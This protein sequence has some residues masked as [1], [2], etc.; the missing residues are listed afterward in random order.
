MSEFK[1]FYRNN[2]P[3]L[4]PSLGVFFI[5]ARL[6]GSLSPE[7]IQK[8]REDYEL[9]YQEIKKHKDKLITK[10][11]L[12][13]A[14]KRQFARLDQH[15]DQN[16]KGNHWLKQDQIARV[17][18]DALHFWDGQKIELICYTIMSNHFHCVLK[19]IDPTIPLYK[20]LQS[21]KSYSARQSN[22]ILKRQGKFWQEESYDHLVRNDRE[23]GNII[24]YVLDNP[25]KAGLCTEPADWKWNYV[26]AD[27][28]P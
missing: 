8:I 23:L 1:T 16:Q 24:Q 26:H 7:I 25:V 13:R 5:T 18:Q 28:A 27:Y 9:E 15:L 12:Y 6:Y 20:L 3:H 22:A 19:L 4:Q 11:K 2:L 14:Q 21:I 10:E 17:L